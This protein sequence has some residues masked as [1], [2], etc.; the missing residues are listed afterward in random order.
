MTVECSALSEIVTSFS[1]EHREQFG[2]EGGNM[3]CHR[4]EKN[5]IKCYVLG[6]MKPL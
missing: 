3:L 5:A 4:I 2:R 1:A 6:M